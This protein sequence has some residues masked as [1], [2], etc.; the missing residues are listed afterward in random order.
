MDSIELGQDGMPRLPTGK[1]SAAPAANGAMYMTM[2]V[3][4]NMVSESDC[5][6]NDSQ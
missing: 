5:R 4:W 6:M 3:I 1:A 2:R